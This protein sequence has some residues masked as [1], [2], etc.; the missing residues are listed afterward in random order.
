MQPFRPRWPDRFGVIVAIAG[1]GVGMLLCRPTGWVPDGPELV[2]WVIAVFVLAIPFVVLELG[3]GAIYQD[4]LGESCRKAGK[5]WELVG[6]L[7]AGA[8][9]LAMLVLVMTAGHLALAAYDGVLA[10]IANQPSPWVANAADTVAPRGGGELVA[11]AAVLGVVQF[12]LWRGAPAIARSAVIMA[13]IAFTGLV[14]VGGSLLMHPGAMD[15]LAT[16]LSAGPAGWQAL[17]SVEPWLGAGIAVLVGWAC[18]TGAVT[19]YGS[20]LNRSTDA[21]GIG[22]IAVLAGALAQ[23]LVLSVLA[24]G[25]GVIVADGSHDAQTRLPESL[26]AVAAALANSGLPSWWAGILLTVWFVALLALA[27][28]ALLAMSEVLVA[29]VVDKFGLPRERVV[30]AVG[31]LLFFLTAVL[32]SEPQAAGW[33]FQGLVW[34]L[35]LA[36]VGQAACSVFA[37]RLDAVARHLNAYSAFH[38]GW[39]WRVVVAALIPLAGIALLVAHAIRE[40][41]SALIGGGIAAGVLV[42]AVVLVRLTGRNS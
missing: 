15:G 22:A 32:L 5:H 4:S 27:I 40:P 23:V 26:I 33:C 2:A 17:S 6:W 24:I 1:M 30:P 21:I 36:L 39:P 35:L 34:V 37:I 10:A 14:L 38:L 42:A 25:S 3:T 31:L 16:L 18:G 28:P 20:Y 9:L 19:A 12:R 41:V 29:S 8:A 11:I 13:T 7:A